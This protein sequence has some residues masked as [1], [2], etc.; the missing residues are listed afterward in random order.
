MMRILLA[1]DESACSAAAT[2]AVLEQFMPSHTVVHVVT[3]DDWPGGLP[4]EASFAEGPGAAESV[5]ALHQRR[6]ENAASLVTAAADKL[7]EAG[8]ATAA[9]VRFGDPRSAIVDCATEWHAD[10][11]VLGSHGKRGLSRMLS[12]VS[13]SVARRAPCSVE[14]IRDGRAA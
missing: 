4:P 12:S 7:R 3:A 2:A 5:L 1:I 13:D 11:I 8:F 9:S 10:L 14:I 6:R